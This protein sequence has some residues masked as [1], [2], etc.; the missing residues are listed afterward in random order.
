MSTGELFTRVHTIV[1]KRKARESRTLATL[2]TIQ[3]D[4]RT[5]SSSL[6][7]ALGAKHTLWT[8]NERRRVGVSSTSTPTTPAQET[9]A[10]VATSLSAF[11]AKQMDLIE[12]VSALLADP[13]YL[14]E[15]LVSRTVPSSLHEDLGDALVLGL[16]SNGLG[17]GQD[18]LL[19]SLIG[20]VLA[21]QIRMAGSVKAALQARASGIRLLPLY[22]KGHSTQFASFLAGI[23][24]NPLEQLLASGAPDLEINPPLVLANM[25]E[26]EKQRR[27]LANVKA[28]SSLKSHPSMRAVLD[29]RFAILAEFTVAILAGVSS[30]LHLL[31]PGF[32]PILAQI[33]EAS[34]EVDDAPGLSVFIVD[35]L[36]RRLILPAIITP[37]PYGILENMLIPHSFRRNLTLLAKAVQGTVS[38]DPGKL[39]R[40]DY[41]A[42]LVSIL[43]DISL[44]PIMDSIRQL[45]DCPTLPPPPQQLPGHPYGYGRSPS[46]VLSADHIFAL[47]DAANE[48]A[49]T[50]DARRGLSTSPIARHLKRL[51]KVPRAPF[52]ADDTT[53]SS[54]DNGTS[55]AQLFAVPLTERAISALWSKAFADPPPDDDDDKEE[56]H[57]HPWEVKILSKAQYIASLAEEDE[58]ES[59]SED[60]ALARALDRVEAVMGVLDLDPS[61][62]QASGLCEIL[63]RV[64]G[65]VGHVLPR[66]NVM[67]SEA[68][69]ALGSLGE[70]NRMAGCTPVL[71]GILERSETSRRYVHYLEGVADNLEVGLLMLG[72]EF[73]RVRDY[74][75]MAYNYEQIHAVQRVLNAHTETVESFR[76]TFTSLIRADER[77]AAVQK[78]V[79]ALE[80][81]LENTV[82]WAHPIASSSATLSEASMAPPLF[83]VH[84]TR[85]TLEL[86]I[87]TDVYDTVFFPRTRG[88]TPDSVPKDVSRSWTRALQDLPPT[89]EAIQIPSAYLGQVPWVPAQEALGRINKARSPGAKMAVL[90][91]T[92][93]I[94][95]E[96]MASSGSV[97][98]AD[99]FLPVFVYVIIQSDVPWLDL[100]RSFIDVYRCVGDCSGQDEYWFTQFSSALSYIQ[101][102]A[103]NLGAGS[104]GGITTDIHASV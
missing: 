78:L 21:R 4:L 95:M 80:A 23:L 47:I 42:P 2:S 37:E 29:D 58:T 79:S 20:S 93:G 50:F 102:L 72:R 104:S 70:G 12:L 6:T 76:T 82:A 44:D 14:E 9:H 5:L 52:Y 18:A 84:D 22:L 91:T 98:G 100:N 27:Y 89:D 40:D 1:R 103:H 60:Q 39:F 83:P 55:A 75:R 85:A 15:M 49:E 10:H 63:Y 74:V 54:S 81:D 87:M 48:T 88:W 25:P 31:P 77:V 61:L 51:C 46:V 99:D 71:L 33:L 11:G 66:I 64:R 7:T 26:T 36:F 73:V 45:A 32:S 30:A 65:S 43:S 69:V 59:G 101:K 96:L 90:T 8:A 16:C 13:G 94:I 56:S 28:D 19:V 17:P 86:A 38:G 3:T 92:A 68:L 24:R 62:S 41:A 67:I 97:P 53:S 35:F 57:H 34:H